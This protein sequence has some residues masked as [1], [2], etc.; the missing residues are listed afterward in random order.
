MRAC[1][2]EMEMSQEPLHTETTGKMAEPRVSPERRHI[3]C[4]S[5]RSRGH[6]TRGTLYKIYKKNAR[7][8]T[9]GAD[10]VR[11]CGCNALQHVTRATTRKFTAAD[12]EQAWCEPAQSKCT[13]RFH[14]SHFVR[15]FIGKMPG[16]RWSTLIKH[17]PLHSL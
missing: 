9:R 5:L 17:P 12:Q 10:F 7:S 13:W 8:Q 14:K 1:A 11:A 4:A 15:K 6:F 2:V 16:P 3:F